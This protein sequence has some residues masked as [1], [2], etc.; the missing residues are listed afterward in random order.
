[1]F[2]LLGEKWKSQYIQYFIYFLE[3]YILK[4]LESRI[5]AKFEFFHDFQKID[6]IPKTFAGSIVT[7]YQKL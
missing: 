5:P 6:G 2:F 7:N 1:M 3:N 4:Y